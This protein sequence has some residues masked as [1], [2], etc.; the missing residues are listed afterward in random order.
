VQNSFDV[1][2][3]VDGDLQFDNSMS[4]GGGRIIQNSIE[5]LFETDGASADDATTT[6]LGVTGIGGTTPTDNR[7]QISS[8]SGLRGA[9][10]AGLP[11]D[12]RST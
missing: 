10:A 5:I 11:A 8:Y 9:V 6:F 4:D 12:G 7:F 3:Y 2:R 1:V